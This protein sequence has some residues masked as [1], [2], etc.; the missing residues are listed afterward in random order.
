MKYVT[1]LQAELAGAEDEN[2]AMRDAVAEFRRHPAGPEFSGTEP[3]G[4]G[5]RKDWIAVAGVNAWLARILQ[6]GA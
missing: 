1:R 5:G 4:G 6:A 2:R 3:G